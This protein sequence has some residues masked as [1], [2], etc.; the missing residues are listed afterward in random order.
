M[1]VTYAAPF[2]AVLTQEVIRERLLA[3][4]SAFF[5]A[6]ALLLAAIGLYGVLNYDVTRERRNIGIRMTLGARPGH[7]AG[8]VTGRLIAPVCLGA[9]AGLACGLALSRFVQVLLFEV[10]PTSVL[11]AFALDAGDTDCV[12]TSRE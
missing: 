4:L 9:I 8:L 11:G 7:V 1:Q 12:C 10:E 5:A 3:A 2:A 6:L